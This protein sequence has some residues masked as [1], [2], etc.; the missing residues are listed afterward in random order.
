MRSNNSTVVAH[1]FRDFTHWSFAL[2]IWT[3]TQSSFPFSSILVNYLQKVKKSRK[4]D[5]LWNSKK[6]KNN[7]NTKM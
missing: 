1:N 7:N 5:K 6:K 2:L 4:I 3:S